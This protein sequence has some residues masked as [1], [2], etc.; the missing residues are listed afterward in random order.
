MS[1][2]TLADF[3][4]LPDDRGS[5]ESELKPV[6]RTKKKKLSFGGRSGASNATGISRVSGSSAG[7]GIARRSASGSLGGGK[8]NQE[9]TLTFKARSTPGKLRLRELDPRRIIFL[10]SASTRIVLDWKKNRWEGTGRLIER[11][12]P[13]TRMVQYTMKLTGAATSSIV[14]E[15]AG[16]PSS[17]DD[18]VQSE[19]S[20]DD[21]VVNSDDE[22]GSD[23]TG[24]LAGSSTATGSHL[25][26]SALGGDSVSGVSREVGRANRRRQKAKSRITGWLSQYSGCTKGHG[27]RLMRK[28]YKP[29]CEDLDVKMNSGVKELLM[30]SLVQNNTACFCS[31]QAVNFRNFLLGNRGVQALWPLLRYARALKS[32]NLAG[33]DIHDEGARHIISVLEADAQNLGKDD[34]GGLLMVDLSKNPITGSLAEDLMRFNDKRKDVLLLGLADTVMPMVK[35]QKI[36]RQC[37]TKFAGVE[38]HVMLEAWRLAADPR[39]FV[40]RE[41]FIQCE[42]IVEATHGSAI[43][44]MMEQQRGRRNQGFDEDDWEEDDLREETN[45]D[46]RALMGQ[47]GFGGLDED[48]FSTIAERGT[49]GARDTPVSRP[50]SSLTM[51]PPTPPPSAARK[52]LLASPPPCPAGLHGLRSPRGSK[53]VCGKADVHAPKAKASCSRQSWALRRRYACSSSAE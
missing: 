3:G 41:L 50:C 35:R 4:K 45:A 30:S 22:K 19:A 18:E 43:Y 51:A 24:S 29:K 31:L 52:A 14:P 12:L 9:A 33:N 44:D 38:P 20:D 8:K 25:T 39:D 10:E 42:K 23:L 49:P 2:T 48:E 53:S 34:V 13:T 32:L 47:D 28:I 40:D 15:D 7:R 17:E 26:P 1:F 36:L 6:T 46:E 5:G 21:A 37:L 11:M 27:E 16:E